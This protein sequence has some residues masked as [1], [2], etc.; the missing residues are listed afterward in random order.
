MVRPPASLPTPEEE[1]DLHKRLV[2][3]DP[4]ASADL[5]ETYLSPLIAVLK[6]RN[7]GVT[8]HLAEEAAGEALVCLI[9]NP[10]SFNA[11]RKAASTKSLC[12]MLQASRKTNPLWLRLER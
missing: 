2:E 6:R 10:R 7:R 9:R 12:R 3:G 1:R 8:E 11:A 4:V 5:A